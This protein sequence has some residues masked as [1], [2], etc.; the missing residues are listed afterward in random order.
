MECFFNT[1]SPIKKESRY[2]IVP[3]ERMNLD[4][5]LAQVEGQKY[6]VLHARRQTGRTSYGNSRLR[7]IED[8]PL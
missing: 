8:M 1:E 3:L 2:F 6:F 5:T 4:K 7:D